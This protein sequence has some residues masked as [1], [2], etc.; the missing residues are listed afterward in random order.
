MRRRLICSAECD[1]A[2][3]EEQEE[4]EEDPQVEWLPLPL[5]AAV[6]GIASA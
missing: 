1:Q 2:Q 5:D 6:E 4:Q 3:E